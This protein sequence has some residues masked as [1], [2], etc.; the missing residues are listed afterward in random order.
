MLRRY[1][2]GFGLK[3]T[4]VPGVAVRGVVARTFT[5]FL[6]VT[7][8]CADLAVSAR[9]RVSGALTNPPAIPVMPVRA[10]ELEQRQR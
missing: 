7:G 10:S 3:T 9:L 1:L 5:R 2:V 4:V 8:G 6:D